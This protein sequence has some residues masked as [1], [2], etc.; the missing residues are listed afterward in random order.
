MLK[1]LNRFGQ[2]NMKLFTFL[3]FLFFKQMCM[4]VTCMQEHME[5]RRGALDPMA[6]QMV[7]SLHEVLGSKSGYSTRAVVLLIVNHPA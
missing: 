5:V 2:I 6:F 4:Y 7:V 3:L 1:P